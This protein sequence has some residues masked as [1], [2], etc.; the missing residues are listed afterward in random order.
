MRGSYDNEPVQVVNAID[1]QTMSTP[2]L[3]MVELPNGRLVAAIRT[4]DNVI[5]LPPDE[6][7]GFALTL[8]EMVTEQPGSLD[9]ETR[10]NFVSHAAFLVGALRDMRT[11]VATDVIPVQ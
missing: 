1:A 5:C 2:R 3:G 9:R 8:I 6:A 4:G 10:D 7:I 11:H